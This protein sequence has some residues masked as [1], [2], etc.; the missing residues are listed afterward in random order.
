MLKGGIEGVCVCTHTNFE[1]FRDF[2]PRG[3]E[4]F[5]APTFGTFF[6]RI[7]PTNDMIDVIS[8]PKIWCHLHLKMC[9]RWLKSGDT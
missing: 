7:L 6:S 2:F 3:A 5:T 4:V 1:R 8:E 9:T